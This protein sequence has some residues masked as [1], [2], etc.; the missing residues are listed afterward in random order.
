MALP[1]TIPNTFANAT[2]AIPLSQL[3]SNFT[4][5]SN[6]INQ[7]NAGTQQLSNANVAVLIM[8]AGTS[9]APSITFTS[10]TNTGIFSPAAD[11]IAFAEGGAE[12]MRLDSSG[13]LAVGATSASERLHVSTSTTSSNAIAQFTNGT[14]GTGAANGLYFGIDTSNDA[15][16]FNFYNSAIKFGTNATERMRID[17]SGNLGL[18]VTPS[19]WGGS[20]KTFQLPGGSIGAFST[21]AITTFQ[22][23]Y[24]SGAGSYVY[25]TTA[26]A[27]RYTQSQ[28]QHQW[29]NAASGT[30]G[31]AITFTQAMTLDASGNVGI[32]TTSPKS[33]GAGYQSLDVR[34]S[35]GGGFYFGPSGASNYSLLYASA[36]ATDFGTTAAAPLRFYTS[37]TE[38]AR[39]DSSGNLLVGIA[40]ARANAGDVQVSKGISFPATQ[41]AQSDANTLDDYE[42]GTWTP[43]LS[44]SVSNPTVSY[45][46][47][48]GKYTK[49]GNVVYCRLGIDANITIAGSG[50]LVVSLPFAAANLSLFYQHSASGY[51]NAVTSVQDIRAIG[52]QWAL[53][54]AVLYTAIDDAPAAS[55]ATTGQVSFYIQFFYFV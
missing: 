3:D 52:V 24:D 25:L 44:G 40:S 23:A 14:T 32:G 8:N 54:T 36:S 49:I 7:I 41:S 29:F 51:V 30:A 50:D 19:A 13:R 27:S 16:M 37:D 53:A 28:G 20:Y 35:T 45:S 31:N 22:N 34:G 21:G 47:Q 48:D 6:V 18:G 10:D 42:E 1:V 4:T 12:A 2:A 5:L 38:R 9:A 17:S 33:I 11:T 26:E 39:I 15:T 43:V 55:A 46:A